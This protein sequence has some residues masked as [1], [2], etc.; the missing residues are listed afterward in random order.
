MPKMDQ[1]LKI[2]IGKK[3]K[4]YAVRWGSLVY[5]GPAAMTKYSNS[6]WEKGLVIQHSKRI[7]AENPPRQLDKPPLNPLHFPTLFVTETLQKHIQFTSLF[8]RYS[9]QQ[10]DLAHLYSIPVMLSGY[11]IID[12]RP[13]YNCFHLLYFF[14]IILLT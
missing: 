13:V 14:S 9:S 12:T 7:M 5:P 6:T 8:L 10:Q 2:V 3:I 1:K 11:Q 4:T